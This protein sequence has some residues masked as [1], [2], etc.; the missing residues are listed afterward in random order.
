MIIGIAEEVLE[1]V[2]QEQL[3][4][5]REELQVEHHLLAAAARDTAFHDSTVRRAVEDAWLRSAREFIDEDHAIAIRVAVSPVDRR[6]VLLEFIPVGNLVG[7]EIL[8]RGEILRDGRRFAFEGESHL[9]FGNARGRF[10]PQAVDH[11]LAEFVS[12]D[13][14][15][16][17]RRGNTRAG[18]QVSIARH[19]AGRLARFDVAHVIRGKGQRHLFAAAA[20]D[21]AFH[22]RAIR[23]AIRDARLRS[24]DVFLEEG[25][26]VFVGVAPRINRCRSVLIDLE[27]VGN[28]VRIEILGGRNVFRHRGG[29]RID[30]E[31]HL[32]EGDAAGAFLPQAIHFPLGEAVTEV[33]PAQVG[34][35]HLCAGFE[36]FV[37][38]DHAG[39]RG[40]FGVKIPLGAD[41]YR[42]LL[43]A[44]PRDTAFGNSS[45]RGAVR[46]ARLRALDV[47]ID[48]RHPVV[49][50]IA[51]GILGQIA[52]I[53]VFI[54]IGNLIR[55]GI[56]RFEHIR[57]HRLRVL[58]NF[59]GE[60]IDRDPVAVLLPRAVERPVAEPVAARSLR[61]RRD[62]HIRAGR[63]ECARGDN[64]GRNRRG[65]QLDLRRLRDNRGQRNAAGQHGSGDEPL[66]SAR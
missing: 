44:P 16:R 1:L 23:R 26:S 28:A 49:V 41:H 17:I 55:I 54:P 30:R 39:W 6:A 47:F 34:C 9:R 64:S 18:S 52:V 65:G 60:G 5:R 29:R 58:E 2:T 3:P 40:S 27:P 10:L 63:M 48:Q 32:G 53:Q 46:N 59:E 13:V 31:V 21:T 12:I 57:R 45:V 61:G 50:R 56:G 15:R 19:H 36:V 8:R 37:A 11:P 20:R 51:A 7:I 14:R 33:F 22:H 4:L 62:R 43:S 35:R 25:A 38:R 42:D 66:A 24:A